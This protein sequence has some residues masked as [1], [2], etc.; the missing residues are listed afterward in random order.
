MLRRPELGEQEIKYIKAFN[1]L[2]NCRSVGMGANPILL[3]EIECYIRLYNVLRP[4]EFIRVIK[5]MDLEFLKY[6][7]RKNGNRSSNSHPSQAG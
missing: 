4:L 6:E 7:E 1:T 5:A 2:H 3:T